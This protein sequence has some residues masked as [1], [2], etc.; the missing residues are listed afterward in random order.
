MESQ[1]K[2]EEELTAMVCRGPP[3]SPLP[4][5]HTSQFMEEKEAELR[6]RAAAI[7]A[8][9][10]KRLGSATVAAAPPATAPTAVPAAPV[11]DDP[12]ASLFA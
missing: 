6:E 12:Y 1:K 5:T 10:Q 11:D 3:A 4:H 2:Y 7:E 9:V 8:E